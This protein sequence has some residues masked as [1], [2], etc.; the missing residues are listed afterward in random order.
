MG[1]RL[2]QLGA[3]DSEAVAREQWD[4]LNTRFGTYLAGKKRVV[5]KATSGGR[6][7]YRLRAM[8][9][10]DI[11]DARRFCSALVAENADCIPVVTR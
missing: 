6:V 1:T 9:F 8:G 3:F 5:Q 2:A 7:F 11:A 4:Q 10:E